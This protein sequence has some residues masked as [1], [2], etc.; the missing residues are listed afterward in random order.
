MLSGFLVHSALSWENWVPVHFSNNFLI[1]LVIREVALNNNDKIISLS[2]SGPPTPLVL[3]KGFKD[4]NGR[5][6][7]PL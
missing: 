5:V 1:L 2:P 7:L 6:V 4:R 3:R